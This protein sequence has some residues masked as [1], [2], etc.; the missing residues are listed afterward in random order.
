MTHFSSL[1]LRDVRSALFPKTKPKAPRR[2]DFPAPVSPVIIEN[3]S[4]KSIDNFSINAK[5]LIESEVS[6]L[7]V[8]RFAIEDKYSLDYGLI[9]DH[10]LEFF[11]ETLPR[12]S[13]KLATFTDGPPENIDW[14]SSVFASNK[15]LIKIGRAHV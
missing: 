3:P 14:I 2:I 11:G 15:V 13:I 9:E 10:L 4:E 12:T 7:N 1:F 8:L 5:F 6:I